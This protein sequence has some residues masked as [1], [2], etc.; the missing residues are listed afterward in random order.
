MTTENP[1]P[2]TSSDQAIAAA[3]AKVDPIGAAVADSKA[4]AEAK[5]PKP[6]P[7][8][9]R[10]SGRDAI[11]KVMA[12]GKPRKAKDITAEAV[13]LIRP[14]PAGKTPE[15]TLSALLYTQAKKP[16][17]IVVRTSKTAEFKLRP[18]KASKS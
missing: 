5:K 7:S 8:T 15:A 12:D 10:V 9:S 14:K 1:T 16:D 6:K 18:V 4:R 11:L 17:G 3:A 2:E 13:K